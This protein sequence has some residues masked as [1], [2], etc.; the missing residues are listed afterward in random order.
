MK[1]SITIITFFVLFCFSGTASGE[2]SY[3]FKWTDVYGSIHL[4]NSFKSIPVKYRGQAKK[5]RLINIENTEVNALKIFTGSSGSAKVDFDPAKS[6]VIV[7]AIFNGVVKRD[8]IIDTGSEWV[9]ITT[10]LARALGYDFR[11]ARKT[12]FQ[13]QSG[14]VMAPVVKLDRMTIG[15]AQVTGLKAA[16]VDFD[17]RGAVSAVAG[18]NFLSAFVFEI[19]KYNGELILTTPEK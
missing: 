18:M 6:K 16:V 3:V 10:K 19:D 14:P 4:S 7:T 11:K 12:W 2:K 17:G 8:I 1:K 13:T 5:I 9:T 15:N